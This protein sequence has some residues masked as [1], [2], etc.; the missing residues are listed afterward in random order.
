MKLSN[1]GIIFVIV[2]LCL[3]VGVDTKEQLLVAI[4][5]QKL[6]IDQQ[7]DNAVDDSISSLVE[8]DSTDVINLNKESAVE[9]FYKSLAANMGVLDN[10]TKRDLLKVY[11]PVILVT[12]LDGFY[13]NYNVADKEGILRNV[14]TEKMPY[15]IEENGVVYSFFLGEQRDYIRILDNGTMKEGTWQELKNEYPNSELLKHFDEYRR[16]VIINS[17]EEKMKFYINQHNRIASQY[18]ITYNFSLPT[19]SDDDWKRTID[20]ISMMVMFQGYQYGTSRTMVYNRYTIGGAR[21]SKQ[22]MY[23][24]QQSTDGRKYYHKEDCELL[25]D[26]SDVYTTKKEAAQQGAFACPICKP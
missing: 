22:N 21:V 24:I 4:T 3:I 6:K 16:K 18:G 19:I 12:D 26:K 15:S 5:N 11:V 7:I 9:Q 10:K 2:F 13:I 8:F 23:Y 17:I 14:W 20:D 25:T 1:I